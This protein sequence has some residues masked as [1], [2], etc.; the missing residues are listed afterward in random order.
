MKNSCLDDVNKNYEMY[1]INVD[2][3][4]IYPDIYWDIS[5]VSGPGKVWNCP[6][7]F[8]FAGSNLTDSLE[9]SRS[10]YSPV[11]TSW[12]VLQYFYFYLW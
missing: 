6:L 10:K 12:N 7:K 4:F 11:S 3:S 8:S 2:I 9:K 1:G 5:S